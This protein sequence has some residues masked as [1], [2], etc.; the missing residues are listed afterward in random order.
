MDLVLNKLQR[1]IC[2]KNPTNRAF[3]SSPSSATIPHVEN[4]NKP[5]LLIF[6]NYNININ[7]SF[8]VF[9]RGIEILFVSEN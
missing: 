9:K 1:L 6:N 2:H 7:S 8:N 5:T 4:L 3:H